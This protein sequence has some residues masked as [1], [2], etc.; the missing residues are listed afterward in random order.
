MG[1]GFWGKCIWAE[2]RDGTCRNRPERSGR[3]NAWIDVATGKPSHAQG[4]GTATGRLDAV[5]L[6]HL[7]YVYV[8]SGLGGNETSALDG[9]NDCA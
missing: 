3:Y 7:R 2:R 4:H 6:S 5:S 1:K 9:R 8:I